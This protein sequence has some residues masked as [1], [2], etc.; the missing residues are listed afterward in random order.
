MTAPS[1]TVR[2]GASGWH[3]ASWWGPFFPPDLPKKG[4]LA[5]YAGRFC[6]T[7]LNAPFYR[8]PTPA[9]VEGWAARTPDGFRFAWKAS[10]FITHWKRLSANAA[11]SLELMESRMALLGDKLGPVLF[12]LPPQMAVDAPRLEAFLSILATGRRYA[13]EFRHPSWYCDPVFRVLA[14]G[15][16]A[17]CISDHAAAPSPRVATASWIYVRGHGPEGRYAG[18]YSDE[19]LAHWADRLAAWAGEGR[20][21]WCFFDNDIK[22]AAPLDAQRLMDRC[23]AIGAPLEPIQRM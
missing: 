7:E 2:I 10:K 16:A 13:F 17:L 11:N 21:G 1:A 23:L 9:A 12:Q 18:H 14:G 15:D 5:F 22:S 19:A 4:A 3:Y 20:E 6:A 8:T